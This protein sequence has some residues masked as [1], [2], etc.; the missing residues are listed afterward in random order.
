MSA[1]QTPSAPLASATPDAPKPPQPPKANAL[2]GAVWMLGAVI[3]F[4]SMAVT[5]RALSD[6]LDTFEILAYR[7]VISIIA[8]L[9]GFYVMRD[10]SGAKPRALKLHL[11]R[12][13]AHFAGQ[14]LWL[15]ALT[16]IPLAQLFALEFSYP[17]LVALGAA[18]FMGERLTP[19]RAATALVGFGGILIVAQP[20]GAG[21][22][23]I[24]ILAALACAFGFAGSALF[25]KQLTSVKRVSVG[26]VLFWMSVMQLIMG[27][28]CGLAD[29]A[30]APL[31][32]ADVA[33]LVTYALAALGAHLCLT[34]ALTLAPAAV[35]TPIDFLRLPLIA[36]VGVVLYAEK[37]G[38]S[39]YVGAAIIFGANYV[40]ILVEK[41]KN[42]A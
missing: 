1:P 13:L 9:I 20:F 18:L 37:T 35:V 29:G 5:G 10:F 15:F 25:T 28:I 24:G 33:W 40:N 22:M 11:A 8:V 17:I 19:V 21:G 6:T 41:R 23:S 14:N 30:M 16:L 26:G 2:I 34:K 32:M 42:A 4:S 31:L 7:S 36:L 27:L 38:L 12:N 3:G 39:T